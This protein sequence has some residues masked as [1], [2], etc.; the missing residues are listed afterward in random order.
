MKQILEYLEQRIQNLVEKSITLVPGQST[1]QL[2]IAII[3]DLRDTVVS[4]AMHEV[5]IPNIY[6]IRVNSAD[7]S[8]LTQDT[9]WLDSLKSIL[10]DSFAEANLKLHGALSIEITPDDSISLQKFEVNYFSVHTTIEQ[11]AALNPSALNTYSKKHSLGAKYYLL[12]DQNVFPLNRG[13]FQIGRRRDNHLVLEHPSVSRNHTQIRLI[14]GNYVIFDLNS[15]SGTFVNGVKIKQ[16]IL[17]PGDVITL[18]GYSI[19]FIQESESSPDNHEQT[20]RIPK[21]V[22]QS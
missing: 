15:T 11:T 9:E 19:I 18:A 12:Q 1:R 21:I 16:T 22:D 2:T 7:Y 10:L 17:H 20:S 4:A 6:T 14:D 8:R 5:E 13:I 3:H